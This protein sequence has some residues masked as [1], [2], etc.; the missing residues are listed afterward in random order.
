MALSMIIFIMLGNIQILTVF[1]KLE[2][3]QGYA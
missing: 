2:N 3:R 1:V